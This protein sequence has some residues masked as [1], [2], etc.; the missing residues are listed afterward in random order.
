MSHRVVLQVWRCIAAEVSSSRRGPFELLAELEHDAGVS[1][2]RK[3]FDIQDTRL[4]AGLSCVPSACW[5]V[6][7]LN[8]PL[9]MESSVQ[10]MIQHDFDN[11]AIC[12]LRNSS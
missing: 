6:P 11:G 7:R 2:C 10:A 1:V 5:D 9:W 3:A 12:E 4:G 8:M